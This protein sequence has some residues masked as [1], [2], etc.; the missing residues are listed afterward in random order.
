MAARTPGYPSPIRPPLRGTSPPGTPD[1]DGSGR[2]QPGP[3][4]SLRDSCAPRAGVAVRLPAESPAARPD[5]PVLA[6]P[7]QP[8]LS[9]AQPARAP[10]LGD[11]GGDPGAGPAPDPSI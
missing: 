6:S 2:R 4:D 9:G 1:R 8:D 11:R 3:Y 7:P 5:R 10:W